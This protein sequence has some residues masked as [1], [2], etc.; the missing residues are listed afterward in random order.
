[1]RKEIF[2]VVSE[3]ADSSGFRFEGVTSSLEEAKNI[4]MSVGGTFGSTYEHWTPGKVQCSFGYYDV[5]ERIGN[6][7][8]DA[9]WNVCIIRIL[10]S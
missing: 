7:A 8:G 9:Y 10:I 2:V 6:K 1:M 4:S 3:D 5:L